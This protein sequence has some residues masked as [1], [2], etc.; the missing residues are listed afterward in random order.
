MFGKG[1]AADTGGDEHFMAID[2]KRPEHA[3]DQILRHHCRRLFAGA[4]QHHEFVATEAGQDV[5][6]G[7]FGAQALS[8]RHQQLIAGMMAERIVDGLEAV[9]IDEIQHQRFLCRP[10]LID[11]LR[12]MR[13]R[14]LRFS[15]P[16]RLSWSA[17]NASLRSAS[18]RKV[19]SVKT[20]T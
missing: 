3:V 12:K 9:Q 17:R 18:L 5:V 20:P 7:E 11:T 15:K 13:I 16:V 6:L 10:G 19:L 2:H 1:G 4:Q 8:R 14:P